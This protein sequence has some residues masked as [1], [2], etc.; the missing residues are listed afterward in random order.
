MTHGDRQQYLEL[1]D[2]L[3]DRQH[4]DFMHVTKL[5]ENLVWVRTIFGLFQL[6]I[7]AR[8]LADRLLARMESRKAQI[9]RMTAELIAN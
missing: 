3:R 6:P 5:L 4:R 9:Q 7:H 8:I 2:A 1:R